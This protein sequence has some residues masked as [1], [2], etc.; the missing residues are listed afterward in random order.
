MILERS[1]P[2]IRERFLNTFGKFT[3]VQKRAI[4]L[5]WARKNVVISS[6]T[7]SGKTLAAFYAILNEL[8]ERVEKGREERISVV[9]VSPLRALDN[10]IRRNLLSYIEGITKYGIE[11]GYLDKGETVKVGIIHGD[12]PQSRRKKIAE[13][14]P[15]ILV[16]T[17]ER[18]FLLLLRK[19][20]MSVTYPE[21]VI[22][23][24]IHEVVNNKRGSHLSISLERLAEARGEFARIAMSATQA[25]IEEIARF[26]GGYYRDGTPRP[27]KIVDV[28]SPKAFDLDIIPA[29]NQEMLY[30]KLVEEI[31]TARTTLVF[32][33]TR[34][35]AEHVAY[36][37]GE[38]LGEPVGVHHSSLSKEER[39]E[40]ERKLKKGEIT[41]VVTSTS[42][43]LGIDIG[44]V[45]KVVQIGSPKQVT[46]AI[47]RVGRSGHGVDRI[48]VG[49]FIPVISI[50][51]I[52]LIEVATIVCDIYKRKID[53]VQIPKKPYDILAQH[54]LG[55]A[56]ENMI[57]STGVE[58]DLDK[59]Y[60]VVRRAYPY[61]EL[62][63]EE[64]DSIVEM[65]TDL[66]KVKAKRGVSRLKIK[67]GKIYLKGKLTLAL[68]RAQSG[69]IVENIRFKVYHGRRRIGELDERFVAELVP[70]DVIV[71]GGQTYEVTSILWDRRI[72]VVR[73]SPSLLP[74]VPS[75]IGEMLPRTFD[76]SLDIGSYLAKYDEG[77]EPEDFKK[78]IREPVRKRIETLVR[79][80]KAITRKL[81]TDKRI[82]VELTRYDIDGRYGYALVFHALF[83]RRVNR[84]LSAAVAYA[85][86]EVLGSV[87]LTY[88]DNGFVIYLDS[89]EDL[90]DILTEYGSVEGIFKYIHREGIERILEDHLIKTLSFRL[91]F[92]KVMIRSM[93]IDVKIS[94]YRI[95]PRRLTDMILDVM[96]EAGDLDHPLI[97]ETLREIMY[98][99]MNLND[100]KKVLEGI[101][102]GDIEVYYIETE[103]PSAFATDLILSGISDITLAKERERAAKKIYDRIIRSLAASGELQS[104]LGLP[105]PKF[106]LSFVEN[107]YKERRHEVRRLYG[108]KGVK[109]LLS[110]GVPFFIDPA[111][112]PSIIRSTIESVGVIKQY[113]QKLIEEGY[114]VSVR[115]PIHGTARVSREYDAVYYTIRGRDREP[116]EE[117]KEVLRKLNDRK[118]FD[119]LSKE[120]DMP[121][122]RL[123]VMIN[124]L[125]TLRRV[126]VG[127]KNGETAYKRREPPKKMNRKE[128][129]RIAIKRYLRLFGPLTPAEIFGYVNVE[130]EA[131]KDDEEVVYGYFVPKLDFQYMLRED[132]KKLESLF[133]SRTILNEYLLE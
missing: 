119:E 41:V 61:H 10:D 122:A 86:S 80:Q 62:T 79:M 107:F 43:E 4:P 97:R 108:K 32:T 42:L 28:Y 92:F 33:N 14:P 52:D 59:A 17:P 56:G 39:E 8:F 40:V 60:E 22:V 94:R 73:P 38:L 70:G 12:V 101:I 112:E 24:E 50:D 124:R 95:N 77:K 129:E 76:L 81:P 106:P 98:I 93:A 63:R 64:F 54:I 29:E 37:L 125:Q 1:R 113:I 53:R 48:S 35:G 90:D 45:D 66:P 9:Y 6:P 30:E 111:H 85:V 44:T 65:L 126:L 100:A 115:H 123:R 16:T 114:V 7:G 102:S 91:K 87:R 82:V 88:N 19:D 23:D 75:R 83:G 131:I 51:T 78:Y 74:T 96:L 46:K 21:R 36:V 27:V 47:Q 55:M 3:E 5:V 26:L 133:K 121:K 72:V 128:A 69:A 120:L 84:A 118:T 34:R 109:K 11:M 49:R 67:D 99:D 89:K 132:L 18:L 117:E 2:Y 103:T 71:L 127:F 57:R 116:T 13:E 105:K 130:P 25:P 110:Y 58:Y 15:D 31:K 68:V 104:V 20:I